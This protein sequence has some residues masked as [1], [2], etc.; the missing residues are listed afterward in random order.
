[1]TKNK[2]IKSID[3]KTLNIPLKSEKSYPLF[4]F[5]HLQD[6]SIKDCCSA[7]FLL[8]FLFRL[9]QLSELG[10]DEI[11]KAS[12]HSFGMEQIPK[13]MIKKEL[14]DFITPE[15]EKLHV[16]RANGNNLPF[17]GIQ[18]Q[19]TFHVIFIETKFGDIYEHN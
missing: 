13:Y 9:K 12:K 8:G 10:W 4:C 5:K 2:R 18:K 19:N 17:I 16:F 14:P 6:A 15:V 11:R 3:K 1:M 7:K